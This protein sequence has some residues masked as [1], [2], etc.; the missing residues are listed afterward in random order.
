MI[1][2]DKW[3]ILKQYDKNIYFLYLTILVYF[4]IDYYSYILVYTQS[5]FT[6]KINNKV[7]VYIVPS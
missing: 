3:I 6:I 1:E 5:Q 4:Y 2:Y 7:L